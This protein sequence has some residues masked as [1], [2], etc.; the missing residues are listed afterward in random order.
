[1]KT[2]RQPH[3]VAMLTDHG[4]QLDDLEARLDS[5]AL[6]PKGYQNP[7]GDLSPY[8]YEGPLLMADTPNEFDAQ[9]YDLALADLI[10]EHAQR[11]A[12]LEA[13]IEELT[14]PPGE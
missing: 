12:T 3:L 5:L 7:R 14:N 6:A 8:Q 4:H 11:I 9:V 2:P 10:H 1:M 13:R